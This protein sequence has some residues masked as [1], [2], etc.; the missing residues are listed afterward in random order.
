M[1]STINLLRPVEH[2]SSQLLTIKQ[3][4]RRISLICFIVSLAVGVITLA[5]TFILQMSV[6]SQK[7][8][9]AML[10]SQL[11]DQEKKEQQI[12]V[13]KSRIAVVE[14]AMTY[15]KPVDQALGMVLDISRPPS[16]YSVSYDDQGKI[17]ASFK[18]NSIP[19]T[20]NM[21]AT[22]LDFVQNK[23]IRNPKMDTYGLDKDGIRISFS[24][25]PVWD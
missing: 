16:L 14:K 18:A 20:M 10:K 13:V 11:K 15:S 5:V 24:F 1:A 19:E 9:Q 4:V 22:V 8:T 2:N 7:E 23:H 21:A 12:A 3:E 25:E 6:S 17:V